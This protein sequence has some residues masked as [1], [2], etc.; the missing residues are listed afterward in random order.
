VEKEESSKVEDSNKNEKPQHVEE[1]K[2]H[3]ESTELA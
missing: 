3:N 1:E 2:K